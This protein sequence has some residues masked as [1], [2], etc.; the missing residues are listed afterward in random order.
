MT[1]PLVAV[2]A[3]G[4]HAARCGTWAV[5]GVGHDAELIG[6]LTEE[7]SLELVFAEVDAGG[8]APEGHVKASFFSS[9][10]TVSGSPRQGRSDRPSSLGTTGSGITKLG[11]KN[12][13]STRTPAPPMV[14]VAPG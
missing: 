2:V 8:V 13:L 10:P 11:L 6:E 12:A 1:T 7:E 9:P 4:A 5:A 14:A 3:P